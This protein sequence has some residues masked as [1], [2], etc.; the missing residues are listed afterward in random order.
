M[1]TEKTTTIRVSPKVLKELKTLASKYDKSI[2]EVAE[3]LIN[4]AKRAQEPKERMY[5]EDS[6]AAAMIQEIFKTS[7]VNAGSRAGWVSNEVE[8]L[9]SHFENLKE[10]ATKAGDTATAAHAEAKI[11]AMKK[12]YGL[13]KED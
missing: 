6:D 11:E 9:I 10:M 5:I 4:F 3:G 2:G 8:K 12:E 7:M 13:I 1:V